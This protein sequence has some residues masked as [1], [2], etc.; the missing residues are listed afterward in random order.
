MFEV[1]QQMIIQEVQFIPVLIALW[2]VFGL[3]GDLVFGRGR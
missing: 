2:F 3:F 1:I